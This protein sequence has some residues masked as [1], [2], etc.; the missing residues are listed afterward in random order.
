MAPR[1]YTTLPFIE[2]PVAQGNFGTSGRLPIDT[3]VWHTAQGTLPG[4][5]SWFNNPASQVSSN[6][7]LDTN[8]QLYAMLEEFYVPYTNGNY[9]S[10][11]R[12]ITIEVI[13]N[14]DPNTAR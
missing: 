7:I 3:I 9:N 2:K 1:A 11:Q 10:N 6:Y 13:D 5:L 8:G 4:T 12:S 14:G